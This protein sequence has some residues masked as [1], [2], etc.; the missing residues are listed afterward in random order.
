MA[1]T[2]RKSTGGMNIK[3]DDEGNMIGLS[4]TGKSAMGLLDRYGQGGYGDIGGIPDS[5]LAANPDTYEPRAEGGLL[6]V[7][8]PKEMRGQYGNFFLTNRPENKPMLEN[9][10][11]VHPDY[12]AQIKPSAP[13][14]PMSKENQ[15]AGFIQFSVS[16]GKDPMQAAKYWDTIHPEPGKYS[17]EALDFERKKAEIAEQKL[18]KKQNI[19]LEASKP[20]EKAM[21]NAVDL[22]T[23]TLLKSVNDLL[24]M[25]GA[26]SIFGLTGAYTPNLSEK[27]RNAQAKLN[28]IVSQLGV[29]ALN[30]MRA[31]SQTGGAVGQVTEKEWPILQS[32]IASLERA[33]SWESAKLA[34]DDII[35]TV[36]RVKRSAK[37]RYSG[38]YG[39]DDRGQAT[40]APQ[41][42]QGFM[43]KRNKV[44]G[45]I[46]TID[47]E[48]NI[49]GGQ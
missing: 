40:P 37:E 46:V 35:T 45:Q 18:D 26:S 11:N 7:P 13:A 41:A 27:A 47:A 4:A 39:A 31:A 8:V 14:V 15:R 36:H 28:A 33:Q 20:K 30:D 10:M 17:A 19:K 16:R 43:Q 23:D 21:L 49:V 29:R 24:T 32:Q 1:G 12:T 48:G 9:R 3:L 22:T 44:T 34:M 2:I 6:S 5:P 25:D 38:T 42:G